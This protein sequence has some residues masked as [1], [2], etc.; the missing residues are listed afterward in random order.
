MWKNGKRYAAFLLFSAGVL[1]TAGFAERAALVYPEKIK[2]SVA[3]EQLGQTQMEVPGTE[4]C[5][6]IL[7]SPGAVIER[8]E[9]AQME[10]VFAQTKTNA[11][12]RQEKEAKAAA[13]AAKGKT[14]Q[15]EAV[16]ASEN[17]LKLLA[18]IIFCEAGNQP[19]E[20]QVAV[21][22]VVMNRVRSGLFP[23]TIQE[24]IYQKGQFTPAGSG[25]LDQVVQ[26]EG[27][28]DSAMSAARDALAG[29]NPVGN[30][31]YF[32]QGSQ[33][34]KIGDHYFH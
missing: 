28:T 11:K 27:Y 7:E 16:S 25:W 26:S 5:K 29:A 19:Y 15:G 17:T 14:G 23:D 18:S 1:S 33:G 32:D 6:L 30:C 10:A 22:A 2:E 8:E 3:L 34:M 31:L 4:A 20:G 24:V 13:Q 12:A 21:G 9:T